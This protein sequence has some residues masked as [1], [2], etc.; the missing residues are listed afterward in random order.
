MRQILTS[1]ADQAVYPTQKLER[2]AYYTCQTPS[3]LSNPYPNAYRG[4]SSGTV[5][6]RE[7]LFP[8]YN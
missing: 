8:S 3:Y 2:K 6:A 1:N 7:T 4:K 5:I